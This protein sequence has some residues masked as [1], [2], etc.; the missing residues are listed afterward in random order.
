MPVSIVSN[1]SAIFAQ[2]SVL[3]RSQELS[4]STSR[5]SS[6]QRVATSEDDASSLVIGNGLRVQVAAYR[7]AQINAAGGVSL[8]QVADGA[9]NEIGD[10]LVRM[11]SLAVQ[12]RSGQ[13][14]NAERSIINTEYQSL[15][16]EIS[17][18]SEDTTFNGVS[19][20]TGSSTT[21]TSNNGLGGSNL[22][23]AAGIS[24]IAFEEGV[25]DGMYQFSY[26]AATNTI[27]ATNMVTGQT[28]DVIISPNAIGSGSTE[29]VPVGGMG[30]QLTLN[31]NFNKAADLAGVNASSVVGGTGVIDDTTLAV[32][33]F[34]LD[35][36]TPLAGADIDSTALTMDVLVPANSTLSMTL[37]GTVFTATGVNLS[38]TGVKTATLSDGAGN[39]FD[40]SF[41]VT[42]AFDGNEA[43]G[44]A[45]AQM[46][47]LA[48]S[49]NTPQDHKT[50]TFQVGTSTDGSDRVSV[51][52]DAVRLTDLGLFATD[53]NSDM[54]A[55]SVLS[56]LDNAQTYINNVR[57]QLGA[58]MQ[59]LE[60]AG[61]SLSISIEN[62]EATRSA[63]LDVDVASE[64][65][66]LTQN[67]AMLEAS[68][69]MLA[70]ANLRPNILLG[71]LRNG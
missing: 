43:A 53:L 10:I 68:I 48:G 35:G 15:L 24:D 1:H 56:Q 47:Q 42:N 44:L 51:Q 61:N 27:T 36:T 20:L 18:I 57:A 59:R 11:Q 22:L 21:T 64:I 2:N 4:N 38:T 3:H 60:F 70:Q 52:I 5:L 25:G 16:S 8:A 67:Q 39:S 37:N 45:L 33:N 41:E 34:V 14:S 29:M 28:A 40:V 46:G 17:R 6:G 13:I 55:G 54:A 69:S 26:A 50:F 66:A 30:I 65:T 23:A 71:L 19:L 49:T 12:A 58:V 63:L 32:S 31:E 62:A 7:T 9:L